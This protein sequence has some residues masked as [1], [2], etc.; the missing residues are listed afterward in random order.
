MIEQLAAVIA[1]MRKRVL[2]GDPEIGTE[3]D[4]LAQHN[5]VDLKTARAVDG[6]TLLLL[7]SP[8]GAPEPSRAWLVAELLYLDALSLEA[9]GDADEARHGFAKALLLYESIDATM[10][11]GLPEAND[12]I[13]E[14]RVRLH[15]VHR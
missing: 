13:G 10:I 15:G 7:L 5:D 12:R 2:G 4:D 9:R 6:E 8:T 1:R 11:G 3:L 14:V